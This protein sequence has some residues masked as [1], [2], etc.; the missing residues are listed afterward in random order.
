MII[1]NVNSYAKN[2]YMN[3]SNYKQLQKVLNS[4]NKIANI[5]RKEANQTPKDLIRKKVM[6]MNT[7]LTVIQNSEQQIQSGMT[8]LQKKRVV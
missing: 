2:P 5:N 4:N 7:Q 3:N 8:I 1:G 6:I